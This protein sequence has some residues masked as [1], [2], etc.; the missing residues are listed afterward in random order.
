MKK[1]LKKLTSVVLAAGM[2]TSV[3]AVGL[4]AAAA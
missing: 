3:A 2:L 1:N 4:S